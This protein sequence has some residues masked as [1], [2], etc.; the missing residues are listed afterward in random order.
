MSTL[1]TIG[2]YL[3]IASLATCS[4]VGLLVS[5]VQFTEDQ[6]STDEYRSVPPEELEEHK[7]ILFLI[8]QIAAFFGVLG[9]GTAIGWFL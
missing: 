8:Q 7:R 4:F 5:V 1:I 3:G 9:L 2:Q 6:F